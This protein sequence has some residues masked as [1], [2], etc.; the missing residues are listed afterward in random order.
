M[1]TTGPPGGWPPRQ[2]FD[3]K[4]VINESSPPPYL[5]INRETIRNP[6]IGDTGGRRLLS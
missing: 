5:L 4:T 6:L 2:D 1:N 3:E